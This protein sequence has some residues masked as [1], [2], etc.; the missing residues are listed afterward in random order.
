MDMGVGRAT[1]MFWFVAGA[2]EFPHKGK[3]TMVPSVSRLGPAYGLLK[4]IP[5]SVGLIT[6]TFPI[7]RRRINTAPTPTSTS[8]AALPKASATI[9]KSPDDKAFAGSADFT[10]GL[11]AKNKVEVS[12]AI[13]IFAV[14]SAAGVVIGKVVGSSLPGPAPVETAVGVLKATVLLVTVIGKTHA[15]RCC[16]K[17]VLS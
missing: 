17:L 3:G 16:V 1:D 9:R 5:F 2:I 7:R 8:R 14:E 13:A 12:V 10:D 6:T 4:S 15:E 11:N